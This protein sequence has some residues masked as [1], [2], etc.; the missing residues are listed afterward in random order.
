MRFVLAKQGRDGLWRDFLTPAGEASEWP[1]GFIGTALHLAR[2]EASGLERAAETLI[3][4]QNVDGGWGYNEESRP[5]AS[6]ARFA[7]SW[8][9]VGGCGSTAGAA[10]IPR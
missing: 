6:P 4:N 1:T 3:A 5:T 9:W 8:A 7:G 2:A 10:R